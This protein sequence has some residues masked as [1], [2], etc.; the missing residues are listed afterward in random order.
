MKGV[1][2]VDYMIIGCILIGVW[3]G[4]K[5]IYEIASEVTFCRLHETNWY[6]RLS[7]KKPIEKPKNNSKNENT[8]I[9]F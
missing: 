4:V 8:I 6:R 7:G 9:V 1:N 5:F 3:H 2:K